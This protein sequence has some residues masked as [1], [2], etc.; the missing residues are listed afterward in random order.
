M[1]IVVCMYVLYCIVEYIEI[2]MYVEYNSYISVNHFS[3][4][5]HC[6]KLIR[7][8]QQYTYMYCTYI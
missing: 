2:P 6:H 3:I 1:Y 8:K 4:H 7:L 5:T